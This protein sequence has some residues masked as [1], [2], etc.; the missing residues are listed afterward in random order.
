VAL[1]APLA[2]GAQGK[3]LSYGYVLPAGVTT[4][5]VP[6]DQA[7]GELDFLLEDTVAVV[8]APGLVALGVDSIEQRWFARYRTG[9]LPAGAIVTVTL[10]PGR[11]RAQRL[12]PFA[13]GLIAAA[14]V[15]GL[16]I[17]LRRKP[18]LASDHRS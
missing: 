5:T 1:F 13:V 12:L 7:T 8:S 10:P 15:A 6:V 9:P 14:L 11:F 3:Q 17:A 18:A 4:L 16:V 2:P